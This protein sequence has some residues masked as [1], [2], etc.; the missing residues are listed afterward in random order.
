MS[1]TIRRRQAKHEYY[2]VLRDHVRCS[3]G[4]WVTIQMDPRSKQGRK[5]IKK[6]HS[7]STRT[8]EMVPAWFRRSMNRRRRRNDHQTLHDFYREGCL[9]DGPVMRY[10]R[11]DILWLWW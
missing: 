5:R 10:H 6:F 4:Y 8:M 1:K 9:E 7:D 11:S 2:W 3:D